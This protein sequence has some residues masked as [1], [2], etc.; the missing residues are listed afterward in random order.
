MISLAIMA[1]DVFEAL[2]KLLQ[3]GDP[4]STFD[5]LI[6]RYRE[7]RD[8]RSL[9]E[10]RLMSKRLELGLPV[11]QL[12]DLSALPSEI[13]AAYGQAVTEVAREVGELFLADGEIAN[14]WPYLRATGDSARVAA[15]IETV[16]PG[17]NTRSEEHTSEL[18]SPCNL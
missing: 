9:F 8:Y 2:E 6:H 10:A 12:R 15:A 16:E 13:Q 1:E 18:Q 3:S 17:D 7:T 11:Y 14:A 5:F 4:A